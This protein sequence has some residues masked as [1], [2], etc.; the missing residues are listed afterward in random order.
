LEICRT[1]EYLCRTTCKLIGRDRN[2][3]QATRY[4]CRLSLNYNRPGTRSGEYSYPSDQFFFLIAKDHTN[5]VIKKI[6]WMDK[7]I[8]S[9]FCFLCLF[10]SLALCKVGSEAVV[11]IASR[12]NCF[13]SRKYSFYHE[14]IDP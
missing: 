13:A 11:R 5:I 8:R 7:C 2:F 12:L 1:G 14:Y 9:I 6:N 3:C 4:Y 10:N